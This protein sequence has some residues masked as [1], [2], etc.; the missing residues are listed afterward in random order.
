MPSPPTAASRTLRSGTDRRRDVP[1]HKVTIGNSGESFGC[2]EDVHVLAA[3]EHACCHG[4]PVGCRNG[5]CGA[6]KVAIEA[7][8]YV[9][10]KMN[11]AV[12]SA[13]EE[14]AR[15]VLACKAYPRGDLVVRA[16][17][18]AWQHARPPT[19][20]SF[21]FGYATTTPIS[22]PDKET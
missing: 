16:L 20:A 22:P 3:M 8:D 10:R 13:E 14:A 21:S 12:V 7:G 1:V 2:A 11:R 17:G 5:G 4:I 15:H 9:T 18:R 19:H 6:C